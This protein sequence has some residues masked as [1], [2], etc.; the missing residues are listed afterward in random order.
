MKTIYEPG[1]VRWKKYDFSWGD[2]RCYR[3]SKGWDAEAIY[4]DTH[5]I[6]GKQCRSIQ[7]WIREEYKP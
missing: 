7:W 3:P 2:I 6:T 4:T 1:A 5:P